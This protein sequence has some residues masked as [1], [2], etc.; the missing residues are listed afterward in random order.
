MREHGG[1][2]IP[3]FDREAGFFRSRGSESNPF[4]S[5]KSLFLFACRRDG[6]A[7]VSAPKAH[8]KTSPRISPRGRTH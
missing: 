2:S 6:D 3:A 1:E 4:K 7:E 8:K 5:P